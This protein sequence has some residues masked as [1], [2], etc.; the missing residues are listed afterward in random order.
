[1]AG[2]CVQ[3]AAR[4]AD[5]GI[6]VTVVDPRWTKPVDEALVGAARGSRYVIVV[7]DSGRVGGF[8]DAVC[9]LLCDHDFA[10]PMRTYWLPQEF[11]GDGER[12]EILADAGLTP[13]HLA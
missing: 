6:S 8:G 12:K 9:R 13:Q 11:L 7:E 10:T 3:T 4:L 2:V 5:Q 1:M